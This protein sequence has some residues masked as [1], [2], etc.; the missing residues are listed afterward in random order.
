MDGLYGRQS[1]VGLLYVKRLKGIIAFPVMRN[2][3]Q[4]CR[5]SPALWDHTAL[6]VSRHRWTRPA[7]TP[8]RQAHRYSICLPTGTEGWVNL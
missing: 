6:P 3:F 5:T 7:T 4:S 1:T 8:A 2:P